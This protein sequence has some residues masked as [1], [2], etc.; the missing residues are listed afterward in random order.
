LLLLLLLLYCYSCYYIVIITLVIITLVIITLVIIT[1]VII[2]FV[3]VTL[4]I[5]TLVIITLVIIT[6][7]VPDIGTF[8][9]RLDGKN[10]RTP[11]GNV[12]QVNSN[13]VAELIASE[14]ARQEGVLRPHSLPVVTHENR[15]SRYF[16]PFMAIFAMML[17]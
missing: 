3:I 15:F 16:S 2:T 6:L 10:L 4:V 8:V 7:D 12:V 5:I 9:V 1:L 13:M 17:H 11:A 14:W